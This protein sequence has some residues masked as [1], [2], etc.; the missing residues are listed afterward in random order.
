[1]DVRQQL[2][3]QDG[4]LDLDDPDPVGHEKPNSSN[5]FL[6]ICDHA[7]KILPK[8]FGSYGLSPR[9]FE[10]HV[11]HDVG[12]LEVSVGLSEELDAEL[13]YQRYSRVLIDC[14]RPPHSAE[15]FIVRNDGTYIEGN[16]HLHAMDAARRVSEIF[17]PYHACIHQ[18]IMHRLAQ[19]R[20]PILVA[21]HSF[22]PVHS[23]HPGERPW[24]VGVLYNRDARFASCVVQAFE[25]DGDVCV[26]INEPYGVDDQGDY[27]IPVHAE[28]LGLLHVELEIR[29]DEISDS[30]GQRNWSKRIAK[31]LCAAT[32]ALENRI[33]AEAEE[34]F[35]DRE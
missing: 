11:T 25:D 29:Q 20:P 14:N 21:I 26:G 23:E 16:E 2:R 13:V 27:A 12:A 8:R 35:G 6:I 17:H 32:S 31:V 34:K 30:V 33:P 7:G 28:R 22:T 9:D 5:D 4:L 24:H 3:W 15:A 10:R 19:N 18:R 1:M